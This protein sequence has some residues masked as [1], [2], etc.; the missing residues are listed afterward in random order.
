MWLKGLPGFMRLVGF[1]GHIGYAVTR[2]LDAP[3][4][5]HKTSIGFIGAVRA[6]KGV[7]R[8]YIYIYIYTG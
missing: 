4:R 1:V 7:Y 2:G 8:V 5:A 3:H 6:S